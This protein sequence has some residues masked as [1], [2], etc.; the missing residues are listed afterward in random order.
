MARVYL[1][2]AGIP[3]GA[4]ERKRSAGTIDGIRY[5]SEV[6]LNAMEVE[7]VQGVRMSREV[8]DLPVLKC[9]VSLGSRALYSFMGATVT[10]FI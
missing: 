8:G 9:G 3:L 2:P 4:R 10:S 5:V 7:F 1:G 6:G